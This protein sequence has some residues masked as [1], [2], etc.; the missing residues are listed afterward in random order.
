MTEIGRVINTNE[1]NYGS[2]IIYQR[3]HSANIQAIHM[4]SKIK[5]PSN[6]YSMVTLNEQV[7][8]GNSIMKNYHKTSMTSSQR[9]IIKQ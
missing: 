6:S 5:R 3:A 9:Q 7:P 2:G 8:S 1:S 4:Q